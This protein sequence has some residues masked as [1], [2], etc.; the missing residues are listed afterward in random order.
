MD[1]S[2]EARS[3]RNRNSGGG[4]T[5]L[6]LPSTF[7]EG[8]SGVRAT[9]ASSSITNVDLI[10]LLRIVGDGLGLRGVIERGLRSGV[11]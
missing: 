9:A 2:N 5:A 6:R 8:K 3:D 7:A 10:G 1:G 11:A 4:S